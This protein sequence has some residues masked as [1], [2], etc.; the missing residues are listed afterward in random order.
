M[1]ENEEDLKPG[2]RR[3]DQAAVVLPFRRRAHEFSPQRIIKRRVLEPEPGLCRV[4]FQPPAKGGAY[5][6]LAIFRIL[7]RRGP[8]GGK[9][10]IVTVH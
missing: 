10:R 2:P 5:I 6:F 3:D 8:G 9:A 4:T 7:N 1:N